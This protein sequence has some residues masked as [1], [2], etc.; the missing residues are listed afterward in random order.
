MEKF[1]TISHPPFFEDMKDLSSMLKQSK[2][3][4]N[5]RDENLPDGLM[6][7]LRMFEQVHR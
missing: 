7:V 1:D 2:T 3:K 4:K 5:K 6:T